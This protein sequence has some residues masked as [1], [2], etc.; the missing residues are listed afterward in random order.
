MLP[1]DAR[2]W[3]YGPN[4]PSLPRPDHSALNRILDEEAMKTLRYKLEQE[5]ISLACISK[6]AEAQFPPDLLWT[7]HCDQAAVW[8]E[9]GALCAT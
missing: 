3:F 7:L 9:L 2:S 8:D 1:S 4:P 5:R 6:H